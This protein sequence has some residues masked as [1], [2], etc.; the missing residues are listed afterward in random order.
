MAGS[1]ETFC[2]ACLSIRKA[3][4]HMSNA[5]DILPCNALSC[6]T[7]AIQGDASQAFFGVILSSSTLLCVP[8]SELPVLFIG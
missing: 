4:L 7:A 6:G 1:A 2:L 3:F 5:T 8:L